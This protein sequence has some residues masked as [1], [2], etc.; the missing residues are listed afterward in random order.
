MTMFNSVYNFLRFLLHYMPSWVIATEPEWTAKPKTF[1]IRLYM[2][3]L[4]DLWSRG[5]CLSSYS[6]AIQGSVREV[7]DAQGIFTE[8]L[9]IPF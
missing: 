5:K 1:T 2:K 4:A 7:A 9:K 8:G 6:F 3:M